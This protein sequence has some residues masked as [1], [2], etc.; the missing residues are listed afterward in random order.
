MMTWCHYILHYVAFSIHIIIQSI[1]QT[2][3][4]KKKN[5]QKSSKICQKKKKK[6]SK[7][8]PFFYFFLKPSFTASFPPL[9][10]SFFFEITINTRFPKGQPSLQTC[11]SLAPL[12]SFR[13]MHS[14]T[15]DLPLLHQTIPPT[16]YQTLTILTNTRNGSTH[17]HQQTLTFPTT[18]RPQVTLAQPAPP[19]YPTTL[20]PLANVMILKVALSSTAGLSLR[21]M[22][23]SNCGTKSI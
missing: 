10:S 11:P 15:P 22:G 8:G 14:W 1:Y 6:P 7:F 21:R 5:P 19:L 3:K 23:R 2:N 17:T 12:A 16:S 20:P 4:K 9:L 13:K 18:T